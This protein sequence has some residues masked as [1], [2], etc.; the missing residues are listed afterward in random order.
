MYSGIQS[1]EERPS[2]RELTEK[3]DPGNEARTRLK[4]IPD[5]GPRNGLE[6][7]I[8]ELLFHLLNIRLVY[9]PSIG[10]GRLPSSLPQ[11]PSDG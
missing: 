1:Q 6:I 4:D 3:T 9:Q 11:P 8:R 2:R 7:L 10:Q 5:T